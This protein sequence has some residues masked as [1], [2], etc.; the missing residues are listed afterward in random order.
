MFVFVRV[1][2]A[3]LLTCWPRSLLACVGSLKQPVAGCSSLLR[4][5][6]AYSVVLASQA[7][8]LAT[9][10]AAAD[11]RRGR[12]YCGQAAR[13]YVVACARE[14]PPLARASLHL[15]STRMRDERARERKRDPAMSRRSCEATSPVL[16]VQQGRQASRQTS[17][18]PVL[19]CVH[20]CAQVS[21]S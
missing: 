21:V 7:P 3:V 10:A 4:T 20:S 6:D 11:S 14:Q 16:L 18:V 5:T 19:L 9:A 8:A 1:R 15:C 17:C 13:T 2:L 12:R